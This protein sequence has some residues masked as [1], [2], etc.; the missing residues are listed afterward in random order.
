MSTPIVPLA[1][2]T[3]IVNRLASRAFAQLFNTRSSFGRIAV[4]ALFVAHGSLCR[5]VG[6][7]RFTTS[8]CRGVDDDRSQRQREFFF[9]RLSGRRLDGLDLEPATKIFLSAQTQLKTCT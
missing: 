4:I 9:D 7:D 1:F 5:G 8:T 6:D 2:C 3:A